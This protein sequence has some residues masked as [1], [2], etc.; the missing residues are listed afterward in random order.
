MPKGRISKKSVDGLNCRENQDRV[1]LWDDA[2]AG[3]GVQSSAALGYAP[4]KLGLM[5]LNR[6]GSHSNATGGEQAD[7]PSRYQAQY[8]PD[9]LESAKS[10]RD[11]LFRELAACGARGDSESQILLGLCYERGI[12]AQR[13]FDVALEWYRRAAVQGSE[14]GCASFVRLSAVVEGDDGAW[15][16]LET[17]V[18]CTLA[19]SSLQRG[20][21]PSNQRKAIKWRLNGAAAGDRYACW[22]L[23][24]LYLLGQSV[25][26]DREE[27]ATWLR[28][29]CE[30][31]P[32]EIVRG[33]FARVRSCIAEVVEDH[34]LDVALRADLNAS[35]A[36]AVRAARE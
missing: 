9:K 19:R 23:H 28:R 30:D 16:R 6:D 33:Y 32:D 11:A 7:A 10:E 20:P 15:D 12:L 25:K 36:R 27:S 2:L 29:A 8:A 4:S 1:F 26:E 3:F 22:R 21:E 13:N 18:V 5:D 34:V 14:E 35:D 24:E 17:Q 31:H